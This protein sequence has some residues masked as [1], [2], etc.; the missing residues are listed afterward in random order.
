MLITLSIFFIYLFGL[1]LVNTAIF[2][3]LFRP[4]EE[5]GQTLRTKRTSKPSKVMP[6]PGEDRP[7][8]LYL[9]YFL[10]SGMLLDLLIVFLVKDMRVSFVVGSALS[11]SGFLYAILKYRKAFLRFFHTGWGAVVLLYLVPLF[12]FSILFMPLSAWDARSIWFF[13]AKMIYYDRGLNFMSL[14]NP[15]VSFSHVDYPDIVPLL[16][17][18]IAYLAGFWNEFLPKASLLVMLVP[19]LLA[20]LSFMGKNIVSFLYLVLMLFFIGGAEMWSGYMDGYLALYA[21]I[22]VLLIG[23]WLK[24]R[25]PLDLLA[26]AAFLA[27]D[28]NIK[29][30][31]SFFALSAAT[32]LVVVVLLGR[33]RY[34]GIFKL[35]G[36]RFYILFI[37]LF[38]PFLVWSY[39]KLKWGLNSDMN[40]GPS[41]FYRAINRFREGGAVPK[42]VRTLVLDAGVGRAAMIFLAVFLAAKLLRVRSSPPVWLSVL[43]AFIYLFGLFLIFLGTPQ[44]IAW[45]LSS[46]GVR[47]MLPVLVFIFCATFFLLGDIE[48]NANKK[49]D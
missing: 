15:A 20:A 43:T 29:N 7:A 8:L 48:K 21:A 38:M 13:H 17:A 12:S 24:N 41:F 34:R 40:I 26:G 27:A 37:S 44:P 33:E 2:P 35:P 28:M 19:A 22:S 5:S 46:A 6:S 45:Q 18:Q 23:R 14:K 16:G 31:G 32:A 9:T 25:R 3:S 36:R 47:T 39:E 1:G 10:M 11:L 30:E 4:L 49:F 42:I